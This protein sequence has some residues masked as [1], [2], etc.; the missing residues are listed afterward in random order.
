MSFLVTPAQLTASARI[1]RTKVTARLELDSTVSSAGI[2]FSLMQGACILY[3]PLE[4]GGGQAMTGIA[5][6]LD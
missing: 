3:H 2:T 4:F 5:L 6:H 1:S